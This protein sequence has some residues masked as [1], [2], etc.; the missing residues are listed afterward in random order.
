[1][2]LAYAIKHAHQWRQAMGL[3][4]TLSLAVGL[5]LAIPLHAA[6]YTVLP[7]QSIDI[8]FKLAWNPSADGITPNI[9]GFGSAPSLSYPTIATG[10]TTNLYNGGTLLGSYYSSRSSGAGADFRSAS[11]TG[12]SYS[13]APVVD[14][15]SILNGSIQGRFQTTF[16][17][18]SVVIDPLKQQ[19]NTAGNTW[20][21]LNACQNS[22][23][24]C[25]DSEF[26]PRITDIRVNNV[27]IL[28]EPRVFG[29]AI[30]QNDGEGIRG[31]LGA[32]QV[33]AA[34]KE[35]PGWAS[36]AQGNTA[37]A[38]AINGTPE[39]NETL[40]QQ[41]NADIVARLNTIKANIRPG[42]TFVFYA[43]AHVG[44][45]EAGSAERAAGTSGD[46]RDEVFASGITDDWL[47]KYFSAP[48]WTNVRKIFLLDTCYSGG[49][50]AGRSADEGDLNRLPNVAIFASSRED[51]VSWATLA[52]VGI[53]TEELLLPALEDS[54]LTA[55]A[56]QNSIS[57]SYATRWTNYIGQSLPLLDFDGFGP[58]SESIF[59]GD[60]TPFF[61]FS[62]DFDMNE[63]WFAAASVMEPSTVSLLLASLGYVAIRRRKRIH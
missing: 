26:L 19:R 36:T 59:L 32:K 31:D 27:S 1:M 15:S 22:G 18:G 24:S 50:W 6:P 48:E 56:L 17:G 54:D 8:Y 62:D 10:L 49:F 33:F 23:A 28:P 11:L 53:W 14:F 60:Q 44:H 45:T 16:T 3:R 34:L 9:L 61:A 21:Q 51:Q 5:S 63:R 46:T 41:V 58:G 47:A 13:Y 39:S 37:G 52:G 29:L 40:R 20:V 55:F 2:F 43:N 35:Q 30:G 57:N 38:Y 12:T 7:G 4:Q 25:S 42:D